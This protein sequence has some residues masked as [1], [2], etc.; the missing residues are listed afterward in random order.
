MSITETIR[1]EMT[2][3]WKAGD[4]RRRDTLRLLMAAFENA[5]IKARHA[6]SDDEALRVLQRE[7]KRRRDS[8][9]EYRN[10][11]REDLAAVEEEEL[12][13]ISAYLPQALSDDE[14]RELVRETIAEVAAAGPSDLGRV[15]GP[16][17]QRVAGRADGR[18]ANE[19][20]RE[21]LVSG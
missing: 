6:L 3:A 15:M 21:L 10:G 19:L 13:V 17:M 2:T 8:I 9:G 11:K 14:L 16:L 20:V 1:D 4:T 7:A 18:R 5:R 12:E